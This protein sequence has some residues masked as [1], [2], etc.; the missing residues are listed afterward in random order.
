[1]HCIGPLG[2]A[3]APADLMQGAG[4]LGAHLT[5]KVNEASQSKQK[6]HATQYKHKVLVIGEKGMSVVGSG[7]VVVEGVDLSRTMDMGIFGSSAAA[8]AALGIEDSITA[9]AVA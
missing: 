5:H 2:W 7:V 1:M 3:A 9:A 4:K 8:A 6:S